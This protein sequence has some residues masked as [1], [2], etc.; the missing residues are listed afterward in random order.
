MTH[1]QSR[2]CHAVR[3]PCRYQ[4]SACQ[5]SVRKEIGFCKAIT[6]STKNATWL[7]CQMNVTFEL[8]SFELF[9]CINWDQNSNFKRGDKASKLKI[10]V[11]WGKNRSGGRK[12]MKDN[13]SWTGHP[14]NLQ[15]PPDA[16][17][18]LLRRTVVSVR[19]PRSGQSRTATADESSQADKEETAKAETSLLI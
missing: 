2:R 8:Y 17:L 16:V 12:N 15:Y 14:L 9:S 6:I 1:P 4:F 19:P 3:G 7:G 13:R 18:C 5:F 10:P 11:S